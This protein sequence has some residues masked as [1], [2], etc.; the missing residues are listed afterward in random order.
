VG[1][2]SK[3]SIQPGSAVNRDLTFDGT[4]ENLYVMTQTTVSSRYGAGHDCWEVP[5]TRMWMSH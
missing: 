2:Y 1:P 5:V 3:Q 4:F